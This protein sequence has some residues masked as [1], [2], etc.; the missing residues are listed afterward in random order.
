[1]FLQRNGLYIRAE[2]EAVRDFMLQVARI[3]LDLEGI[4]AW[5]GR[6]AEIVK[7]GGDP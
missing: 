6:F 3:E 1:M 2:A 5:L 7:T 4:M